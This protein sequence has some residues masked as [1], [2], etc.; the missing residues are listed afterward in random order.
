MSDLNKV[1]L[2]GNITKEIEL[3]KL[4]TGQS[5]CSFSIA[6]NRSWKDTSGVKKEKAEFHNIVAWGKLAEIMGQY[7]TK[8]MKIFIE[9]R[10]ETRAWDDQNGQKKFRTE[11]VAENMQMLGS[12]AQGQGHAQKSQNNVQE[13]EQYHEEELPIIM[14]DDE[15]T[16]E[17][18]SIPF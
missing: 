5:V 16:I 10:L 4:S 1:M 15:E 9:G 11:I 12:K 14:A 13:G 3:K 8:G 7:C 18:E 2:I 6:T 17:I